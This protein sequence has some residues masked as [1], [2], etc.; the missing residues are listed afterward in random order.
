MASDRDDIAGVVAPP[1]LIFM[2]PGIAG[3]LL[4]WAFPFHLWPRAF[5]LVLGGAFVVLGIALFFWAI[6]RFARAGTSVVPY[7]PTTAIIVTGPYNLSRNP[8]YMAMA[9]LYVGIS[10]MAET[11][12]PLLLLPFVLIVVQRGVIARE[13]RYLERKFGNEYLS[14][15]SRVRRWL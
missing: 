7:R 10:F 11:V 13:E 1:P 5:G 15:K 9:L 12:W 2:I 14:Y 6:P 8:I 3:I 4:G